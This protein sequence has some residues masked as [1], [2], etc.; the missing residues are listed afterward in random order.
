M[1]AI[2]IAHRKIINSNPYYKRSCLSGKP[3]TYNDKIVIHHSWIYK[4]QISELWNYMPLLESEHEE[5]HRNLELR[6]RVKLL[7]LER[8]DIKE[9]LIKYPKKN[10]EQEYNY[11]S[12]KFME[13]K[14]KAVFQHPPKK[15]KTTKFKVCQ[16]CKT[17]TSLFICP[18]CG[19]FIGGDKK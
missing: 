16:K 6:E 19:H 13:E 17:S 15:A 2:P 18:T 14:K 5:V 11:L 7:S 9:L 12:K 3:G 8:A 10:W 4:E 1:K